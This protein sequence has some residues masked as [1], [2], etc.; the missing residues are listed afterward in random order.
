MRALAF[1]LVGLFALVQQ[2]EAE[3]L[4]NE[5][6]EHERA[7]ELS[8]AIQLRVDLLDRHGE[9][10]LAEPTLAALAWS[11]AALA[12]YEP[13][14]ERY[15]QYAR[16]YPKS[17]HAPEALQ[18]AYLFRVG[19]GQ[20][21]AALRDLED[22]EKLYERENPELAARIFWS[23]QTLLDTH[24]QRR[25]HALA[26]IQRYGRSGSIDR[27]LVAEA[28]VA[29]IDWRSS[30]AEPLLF[31]SCISL[32]GTES[33]PKRCGE[34]GGDLIV[35]HPRKSKLAADAQARFGR[36]ISAIH[37]NSIKIP[38][39]EYERQ[40][41]FLDAWAMAT[42]YQADADFEDFLRLEVP[43]KL[44]PGSVRMQEFVEHELKLAT[45]LVER[46][47]GV[48]QIRSVRWQT[49]GMSRVGLLYESFA[50][51][52]GQAKVPSTVRGDAQVKSHCE[53]LA[54]WA[55]PVRDRAIEAWQ[56]CL[57]RATEY[58]LVDEYSRLCELRLAELDP[59]HPATHE[60]FGEPSHAP[61]RLRTVGVLP[62]DWTSP[63]GAI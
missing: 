17:K 16:R 6:V 7:G 10:E 2:P 19:L 35:A 42:V 29:Q 56:Y 57:A 58:Q 36:I 32:Q 51:Q 3:A 31:D 8:R 18:N 12:Q 20:T 22:Y 15:E 13:S 37:K 4:F 48:K 63:P 40:A 11:H 23:R 9:S 47:A 1:V 44:D 34:P 21:D 25:E 62:E 28:T 45:E 14:A 33:S 30:C 61:T 24:K 59:R 43:A 50:R 5:A 60:L 46:Y 49:V 39:Y 38:E 53:Q 55:Q 54:A 52:L 27:W 41:S 26:Y